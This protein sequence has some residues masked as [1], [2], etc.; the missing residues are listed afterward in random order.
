MEKEP[1][2]PESESSDDSDEETDENNSKSSKKSV[3]NKSELRSKKASFFRAEKPEKQAEEKSENFK[4]V[5]EDH[6]EESLESSESEEYDE[7][8]E[9]ELH[10]AVL[11]IVDTRMQDVSEELNNAE[12][13]TPEE[14]V[15]MSSSIFL[16][17]LAERASSDEDF[18][19]DDIET[20]FKET[21]EDISLDYSEEDLD[22]EID[23]PEGE[24]S[25]PPEPPDSFTDKIDDVPDD[26]TVEIARV[27]ITPTT[28][29]R[30]TYTGPSSPAP[31]QESV[32]DE[33]EAYIPRSDMLLGLVVGY[34]IGRRGGRKRTEKE[35][36]PRVEK[37]EK[38]VAE[39]T[40]IVSSKEVLIRKQAL[41]IYEQSFDKVDKT[42]AVIE[43]RKVRNQVK[44]NLVKR[45]ELMRNPGVEKIGKFS[46]PALKVFHEKRL[47]D[48]SENSP[49][50]V[51]VEVM[52]TAQLLEKI[53]DLRIN[54]LSVKTMFEKNR[55]TVDALRQ[56]TKEYLRGGDYKKTFSH[57]L[58]PDHDEIEIHRSKVEQQH[59]L[60]RSTTNES[61][62][63]KLV[64]SVAQRNITIET[65]NNK[66]INTNQI[67]TKNILLKPV[68]TVLVI[69]IIL[70]ISSY[71][72]LF[73]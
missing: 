17:S 61:E 45:E 54:N 3:F 72:L 27:P 26:E 71:V 1:K 21:I 11:V 47:P 52:T 44:E 42:E 60:A 48:G 10:E 30:S 46:L 4:I 40:E 29:P 20:A 7:L 38:Q 6:K 14:F 73:R 55:L 41:K 37:L 49:K 16:E 32:N 5:D 67:N 18:T 25:E 57:E 51:Q 66:Q 69:L 65:K 19:S 43:R 34:I 22:N 8:S 68:T 39:L 33:L 31:S 58:L 36:K 13:D 56:I 2:K 53:E 63:N 62:M 23:S 70:I 12:N 64:T 24:P 50:R 15:A 28:I 9:E 59:T 35:Y